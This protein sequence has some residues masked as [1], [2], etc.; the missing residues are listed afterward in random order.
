M[1][2]KPSLPKSHSRFGF[3]GIGQENP[4]RHAQIR[5]NLWPGRAFWKLRVSPPYLLRVC[6]LH[7]ARARVA[8]ARFPWV[9]AGRAGKLGFC[10]L[11]VFARDFSGFGGQPLPARSQTRSMQ[12]ATRIFIGFAAR[13]FRYVFS[14]VS[15][16]AALAP[17]IWLGVFRGFVARAALRLIGGP[18]LLVIPMLFCL[19]LLLLLPAFLARWCRVPAVTACHSFLLVQSF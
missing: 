1:F 6:F 16:L 3:A 19:L 15:P 18:D 8:S 2:A 7:G 10:A 4:E 11:P 14:R 17:S 12:R 9:R 13:R 5:E